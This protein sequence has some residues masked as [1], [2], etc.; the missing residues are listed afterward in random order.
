MGM[1]GILPPA[2]SNPIAS[3]KPAFPEG[4]KG[5]GIRGQME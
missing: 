4:D 1:S 5:T 3:S 2:L